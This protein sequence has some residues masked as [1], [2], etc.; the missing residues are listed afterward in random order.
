MIVLMIAL[1]AVT[2]V[3]M[4]IAYGEPVN[5]EPQATQEV[6]VAQAPEQAE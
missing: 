3:Q 1:L 6:V 2:F 4:Y 5:A